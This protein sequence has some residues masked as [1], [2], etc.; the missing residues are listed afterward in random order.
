MLIDVVCGSGFI[1]T[2]LSRRLSL[3][4]GDNFSIIGKAP[5]KTFQDKMKIAD[6]RSVKALRTAISDDFCQIIW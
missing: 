2:R 5:S 1:G 6:V 3:E 4:C